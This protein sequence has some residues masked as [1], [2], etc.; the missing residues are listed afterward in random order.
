M[1]ELGLNY[2]LKEHDK[3]IDKDGAKKEYLVIKKNK[4][5]DINIQRTLL[6]E[7][8]IIQILQVG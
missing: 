7:G 6:K 3:L 8:L 4:K 2:K 5:K 1:D